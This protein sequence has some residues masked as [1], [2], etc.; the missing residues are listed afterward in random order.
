MWVYHQHYW[1]SNEGLWSHNWD[2][3]PAN[4]MADIMP[5]AL[6]SQPYWQSR[7][8]MELFFFTAQRHRNEKG[9]GE[10]KMGRSCQMMEKWIPW[11]RL[12]W[13]VGC[14]SVNLK[15]YQSALLVAACLGGIPL[16]EKSASCS[17]FSSPLPD[18]CRATH[19]PPPLFMQIY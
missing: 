9:K 18:W 7:Y 2:A 16:Y 14:K 17:P 12:G 10:R 4:M 13:Q 19:A 15:D 6:I 3:S 11:Y 1:T 5:M 8:M